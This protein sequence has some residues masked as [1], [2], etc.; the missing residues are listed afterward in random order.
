MLFVALLLCI[1]IGTMVMAETEDRYYIRLQGIALDTAGDFNGE[2]VGEFV[3]ATNILVVVPELTT[4]KGY[5]LTFGGQNERLGGE[6]SYLTSEHDSTVNDV[7]D[8]LFNVGQT[9]VEK[10]SFDVKFLFS[11][12]KGVFIPFGLIGATYDTY[13]VQNGALDTNATPDTHGEAKFWGLGYKLGL[14]AMLQLTN[15]LA[16]E[17]SYTVSSTKL[18]RV[19]AFGATRAPNYT[20]QSQ[21]VTLSL[22]YYF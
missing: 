1:T 14:G 11:N 2:H 7:L 21:F 17:G 16:L 9:E 4:V 20:A 3:N 6:I 10:Y 19:E 15:K 12:P 18:N 8:L 22:N 13:K 5:G